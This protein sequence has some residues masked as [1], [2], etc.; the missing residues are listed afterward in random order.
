MADELREVLARIEKLEK[1]VFGTGKKKPSGGNREIDFT[2]NERN[3]VNTYGK[4]MSGS[5]KFTLLIAYLAKGKQTDVEGERIVSLWNR[6][7]SILGYS[8]N[9]KYTTEAK[10][11]GWV[12]SK[13]RGYYFLRNNWKEIFS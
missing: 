1:A 11:N 3:F 8:F 10:T 4:H 6:M 13:K 12:D 5:K 2:L 9:P 7:R